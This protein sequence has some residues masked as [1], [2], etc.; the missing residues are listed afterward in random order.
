MALRKITCP[1]AGNQPCMKQD[2]GFAIKVMSDEKFQVALQKANKKGNAVPEQFVCGPMEVVKG[3]IELIADMRKG[4]TSE[5]L[6]KHFEKK[7]HKP[8]KKSIKSKKK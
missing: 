3:M 8:A 2:C 1:L 6:F 4:F 7:K 5:V